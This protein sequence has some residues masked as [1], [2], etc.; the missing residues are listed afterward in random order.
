VSERRYGDS[1][2]S[3][4]FR[5]AAAEAQR[6]LL[7][8]GGAQEGLTLAELQAIGKEAGLAPDAIARAAVARDV[9]GSA[10]VRRLVGL[11]VGVSRTAE[12]GRK[13]SDEEW[14]RLVVRLRETF[15]ATGQTRV[16]GGL[17]TWWNG[18]LRVRL[19]P[20][21]AGQRLTLS[22]VN[23]PAQ[24]YLRGG[25]IALGLSAFFFVTSTVVME[26]NIPAIVS[27]AMGVGF[28]ARALLGLTHWARLRG[29][30]MEQIA[31]DTT[32]SGPPAIEATTR[33]SDSV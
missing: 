7:P 9:Q 30:Q 15:N 26:A 24:S 23:G 20:G 18:N 13:L 28:V 5:D 29:R 27:G 33:A 14:D 8:P 32:V 11:P 3:E 22:T 16:E 10:R 1:E 6:Q 25:L 2:V 4:I 21:A 31:A 12:L 17:R 19:E